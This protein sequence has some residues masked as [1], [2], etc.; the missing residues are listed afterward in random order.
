MLAE[1]V[2]PEVSSVALALVVLVISLVLVPVLAIPT[3]WAVPTP[4]SLRLRLPVAKVFAI[5]APNKLSEVVW[6]TEPPLLASVGLSKELQDDFRELVS[7]DFSKLV[8]E[9]GRL[10]PAAK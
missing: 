1:L 4:Q 10:G 7:A 9:L 5:A 2:Q 6:P 3:S 8:L